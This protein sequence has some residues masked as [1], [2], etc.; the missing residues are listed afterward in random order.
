METVLK[1]IQQA[2]ASDKLGP[3]RSYLSAAAQVQY[4]LSDSMRQV[5]VNEFVRRRQQDQSF[6]PEEFQAQLTVSDTEVF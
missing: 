4:E 2:E 5:L 6:G 1:T 3:V